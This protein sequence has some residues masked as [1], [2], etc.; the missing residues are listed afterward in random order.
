[1]TMWKLTNRV[2][3]ADEKPTTDIAVTLNDES[4]QFS[5]T[6][7]DSFTIKEPIV[8]FMVYESRQMRWIMKKDRV[9]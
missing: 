9:T 4:Y 5:L 3:V 7:K 1:M 6:I 2:D 8:L